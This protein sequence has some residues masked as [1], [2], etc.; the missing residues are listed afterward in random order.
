MGVGRGVLGSSLPTQQRIAGQ[1]DLEKS[2]IYRKYILEEDGGPRKAAALWDLGGKKTEY[3][4]GE[5]WVLSQ[6]SRKMQKWEGLLHL[7]PDRTS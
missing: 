6:E 1:R 2:K 7:D 3:T 5:K 4:P